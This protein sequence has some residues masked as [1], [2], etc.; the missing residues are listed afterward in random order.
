MLIICTIAI[1][2]SLITLAALLVC[3][4]LIKKHIQDLHTDYTFVWESQRELED[5][6]KIQTERE[7]KK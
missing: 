7:K 3:N 2:I 5:I 1:A 4:Y 6:I